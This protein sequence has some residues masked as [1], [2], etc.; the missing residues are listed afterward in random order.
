MEEIKQPNQESTRTF[1]EKEN[2]Y[3]EILEAETIKQKEMKEKVR[4]R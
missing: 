4:K 2:K 3:L 1:G